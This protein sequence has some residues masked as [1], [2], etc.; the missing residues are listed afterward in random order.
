MISSA[1]KAP[2]FLLYGQGMKSR[3]AYKFSSD[4][5]AGARDFYNR[6]SLTL[7][8]RMPRQ[9]SGSPRKLCLLALT[10][11]SKIGPNPANRWEAYV[12]FPLAIEPA[13]LERPSAGGQMGQPELQFTKLGTDSTS[14]NLST[15]ASLLHLA[16]PMESAQ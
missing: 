13:S 6:P 12:R 2:L 9:I 10:I 1:A 15:A 5:D 3:T 8:G 14:R 4:R 7:F 11:K 16:R